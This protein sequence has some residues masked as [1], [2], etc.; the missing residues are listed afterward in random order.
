M[1]LTTIGFHFSGVI[2]DMPKV[3]SDLRPTSLEKS[4]EICRLRIYEVYA[5]GV[6]LVIAGVAAILDNLPDS[7]DT[8]L[9]PRFGEAKCWF[10]E[11][12]RCHDL[13]IILVVAFHFY[14]ITS[15][16]LPEPARHGH[17]HR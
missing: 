15:H 4:Q 14:A 11:G 6:P 5:W 8:Y 3:V 2:C 7:N 10:Y 1:P 16:F 9:R 13:G 12:N 17:R